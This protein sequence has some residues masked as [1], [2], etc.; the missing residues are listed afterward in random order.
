MKQFF[1][2]FAMTKVSCFVDDLLLLYFVVLYMT[3]YLSNL[4]LY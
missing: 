2:T 1:A 3:E 4:I